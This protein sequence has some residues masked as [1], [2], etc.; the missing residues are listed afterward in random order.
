MKIKLNKK[1]LKIL[2]I[3]LT[4]ID[5][6]LALIHI[7]KS[8]I[9]VIDGATTMDYAIQ[10]VSQQDGDLSERFNRPSKKTP[11][12]NPYSFS[13]FRKEDNTPPLIT[14][15]FESPEDLILAYYGI[16]REA[17]NMLGY[18]GGCGTIGWADLPYSYAYE[19][20]TKE[21][22][23][24]MSL[25]QFIDSFKGIGHTTLLK[26]I[27]A[28]AP[29]D[30][31]S[32]IKY[33]M[34]EIEVITGAKA[35]TDAEYN[36][37]SHFA[38]DYGLITVEKA[39]EDEWKI[40]NIDYIPEDFLCAP[41]HGWFYYSD[42]AVQIIYINNLKIA[43]KID[44]T[45]QEDDMIYIYASGNGIQYRFDFVRLTNGYDILLHEN[46]LENGVWKEVD[47]LTD[48]WMN[49]KLSINNS[50]LNRVI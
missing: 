40:K 17:S 5:C 12:P 37:G 34:I 35:E 45:E 6:C 7:T 46:I 48:K 41:L 4:G 33:Y 22:Q 10:A 42:S 19:L 18:S 25:N 11:L 43:D 47:L 1:F 9:S 36:Q 14:I 28:Y 50:E 29:P 49:F 16:L 13:D 24:E 39:P 31:P 3:L 8:S 23:K 21:K 32:D 27:P 20:L 2:I 44:K 15:K 26:L 38:Y 30:T